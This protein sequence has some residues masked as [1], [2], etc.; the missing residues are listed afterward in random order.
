MHELM[1]WIGYLGTAL[2]IIAYL[3]QIYHLIC[4]R[5]SAGVSLR[6]YMLWTIA[7]ALL[8]LHAWHIASHVF[9]MMTG[10]Q[11]IATA[12]I[13][14]FTWKYREQKT[15]VLQEVELE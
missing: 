1:N 14:F 10:F 7:S 11:L 3:P 15:P 9:V 12:T 8:L 5:C 13:G 6:A 2:V 4:L